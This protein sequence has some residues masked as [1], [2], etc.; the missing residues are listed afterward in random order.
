MYFSAQQRAEAVDDWLKDKVAALTGQAAQR[1]LEQRRQCG[2]ALLSMKDRGE[3]LREIARMAGIREKTVRELIRLTE[4]GSG[5]VLGRAAVNGSADLE[6][7]GA[8]ARSGVAGDGGGAVGMSG[9]AGQSW[10]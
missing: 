7:G 1:R 5:D 6:R 2:A 3:S 8:A 9:G 10:R 4:R